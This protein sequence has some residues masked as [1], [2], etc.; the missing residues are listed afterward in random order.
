MELE[1]DICKEEVYQGLFEQYVLSIRNFIY[2]KS[3]D[4]KLSEDIVQDVFV[5]LWNKCTDVRFSTVKP[6][7]YRIADNLLIDHFRHN[8]V[9]LNHRMKLDA[10]PSTNES[11]QFLMEEQEFKERVENVINEMPEINRVVF[12]MN[13]IEKMTYREIAE[14]LGLSQKAIEKRMAKALKIFRELMVEK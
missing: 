7:L 3:G 13:R 12:L 10:S 4:L 11:P 2:S 14:R 1:K 9:V 8:K 6:Y 5:K